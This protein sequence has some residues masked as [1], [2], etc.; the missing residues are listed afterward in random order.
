[1]PKKRSKLPFTIGVILTVIGIIATIVFTVI[2]FVNVNKLRSSYG[3]RITD[4]TYFIIT[5]I[6]TFCTYIFITM[7]VVLPIFSIT[8]ITS[9]FDDRNMLKFKRTLN[10]PTAGLASPHSAPFYRE[11]AVLFLVGL[12]TAIFFS[13]SNGWRYYN[14]GV[15]FTILISTLVYALIHLAV[16]GIVAAIDD[17]NRLIAN[18][19][20][21][22]NGIS[23]QYSNPIQTYQSPM[24]Q[25]N[26][27]QYP[28]QQVPQEYHQ[29]QQPYDP[30][31]NN[32][33]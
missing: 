16:S 32:G 5:P 1:M 33:Q 30:N 27:P 10:M 29:Y 21:E 28:P 14:W 26:Y 17:G 18:D 4:E 3:G 9:A 13:A 12:I 31:Q 2:S 11:S 19:G 8:H 6:I 7:G 25:Q 22:A 20:L 15:F 24:P 23:P